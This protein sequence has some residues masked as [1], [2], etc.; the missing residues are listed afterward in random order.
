MPRS[1]L[2]QRHYI[3][4]HK[5]VTGIFVLGCM[6]YHHAWDNTAAWLYL[7]TH[8]LYGLLW[9]LKSQVFP[10][11]QFDADCNLGYG[12]LIWLSLSAYWVTPWIITAYAVQPPPWYLGLCVALYGT[13]VFFHFASDMQKHVH[14]QLRPGKLFT[15]GLWA[16]CR[17]PNYFG[18]LLIYAGFSALGMHWAPFAALA[19]LIA[20][21]WV[22][23]MRRKER[24]LARFPEFA[25]WKARSN[26]II[27]YL[28]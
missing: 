8:G 17:N 23:N 24:S 3:D 28:L 10:D 26:L 1:S 9:A 5:G 13:G 18:E 22:P 6:A 4:S 12:A 19:L 15:D 7:A 21:V 14:L 27:P 2:K 25:G 11:K 16:R 20:G